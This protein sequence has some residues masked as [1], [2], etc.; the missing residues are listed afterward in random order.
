MYMHYKHCHWATAHLQFIIIIII[1]IIMLIWC[2][3]W[4]DTQKCAL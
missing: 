1:I 4:G 3:L 2:F